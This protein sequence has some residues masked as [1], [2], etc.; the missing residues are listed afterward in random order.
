MSLEDQSL[1]MPFLGSCLISWSSKKQTVISRSST[2]AEYMA[3]ADRTCELTWLKCLFKDLQLQVQS[4]I[5]IFC[6]NS[7]TIALASNPVQHVRTKYI[8]IDYHFVRDKIR[9]KQVLPV[10]ISTKLQAADVLTKGIPKVLHYNCLSK[11]GICDPFTM[12]TCGGW[13]WGG[14]K[15]TNAGSSNVDDSSSNQ[16]KDNCKVNS[17]KSTL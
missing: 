3:L 2:K 17:I 6:D 13:G 9:S 16:N 12:P 11:F 15:G 1:A 7:S 14:G 5:S 10:F 4:P 8:E